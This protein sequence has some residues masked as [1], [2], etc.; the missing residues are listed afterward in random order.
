[1]TDTNKG[2]EYYRAGRILID[3]KSFRVTYRYNLAKT[4][5]YIQLIDLSDDYYVLEEWDEVKNTSEEM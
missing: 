5:G 4:N 2:K 3:K 1:M